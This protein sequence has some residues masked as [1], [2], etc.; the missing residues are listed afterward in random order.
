MDDFDENVWLNAGHGGQEVIQDLLGGHPKFPAACAD[1]QPAIFIPVVALGKIF[2]PHQN[3]I[4]VIG[5][6]HEGGSNLKT[7]TAEFAS[8][9]IAAPLNERGAQGLFVLERNRFFSEGT[10]ENSRALGRQ[11]GQHIGKVPQG[12]LTSDKK[13]QSFLRNLINF[14]V[15]PG[16]KSPGYCRASLR[17]E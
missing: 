8:V 17:D 14:T 4:A 6:F 16:D 15:Q 10:S 1:F 11:V 12:R 7:R 5:E 9:G 3:Q 2:G 13:L